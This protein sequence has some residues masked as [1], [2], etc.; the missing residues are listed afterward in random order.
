MKVQTFFLRSCL[1][2]VLYGKVRGNLGKIWCLR[3]L[4]LKKHVQ[5]EMKCS[6]FLEV[7]LFRV[8]SGKFAEIWAKILRTPKILP[9]RTP[10][11]LGMCC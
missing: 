1:F 10:M 4:D 6:H 5:D 11:Q 7:I 9:A 3:C 2:L 8:F